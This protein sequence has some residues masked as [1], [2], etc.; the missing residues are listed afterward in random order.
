M[1]CSDIVKEINGNLESE[2]VARSS[3]NAEYVELSVGLATLS[4][5]TTFANIAPSRKPKSWY[6]I[7]KRGIIPA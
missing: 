6:L 3:D 2:S 1:N 7:K 5:K 4:L